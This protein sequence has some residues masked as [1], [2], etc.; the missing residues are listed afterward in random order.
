M[1]YF[2]EEFK[3]S[4]LNKIS[5]EGKKGV[6][7]SCKTVLKHSSDIERQLNKDLYDF[8][9][10]ELIML[11]EK[12]G[13][14][15]RSYFG[16]SKSN[17]KR[18]FMYAIA[19]GKIPEKSIVKLARVRFEAI[20]GEQKLSSMY[21]KDYE[22]FIKTFDQI[23]N[24]DIEYTEYF[25]IN[26]IKCIMSLAWF[27]VCKSDIFKIEKKD[28]DLNN[29]TIFSPTDNE[30]ITVPE[31]VVQL[32]LRLAETEYYENYTNVITVFA[33]NDKVL[34]VRE[35]VNNI[36]NCELVLKNMIANFKTEFLPKIL[37]TNEKSIKDFLSSLKYE[38][39]ERNGRFEK[40][41]N[42]ET[43]YVL[44]KKSIDY[45]NFFEI[46][47]QSTAD[48]EF[49]IYLKWKEIFHNG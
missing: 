4:F 39:I 22:T 26:R 45:K 47:A 30:F 43:R 1:A 48:N 20:K 9:T 17:L 6:V 46:S 49:D 14:V 42:Y 5:E 40:A 27:G 31:N 11:F 24:N 29:N 23:F 28:I 37:D 19:C 41:Y 38:Q 21:Y 16:T 36:D 35:T 7:A 44:F 2:N 33:D 8:D 18:Y 12:A 25:V 15:T 13:W 3:C 34:K 10:K 32:C